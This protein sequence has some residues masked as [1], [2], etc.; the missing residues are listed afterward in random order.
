MQLKVRHRLVG[1]EAP[2]KR[3]PQ[4]GVKHP[5][6]RGVQFQ[7]QQFAVKVQP[8]HAA[9]VGGLLSLGRPSAIPRFVTLRI[10]DPLKGAASGA[11]A[12]IGQERFEVLPS[13]ADGDP[14]GAVPFIT[15]AR[16]VLAPRL[17]RGPRLVGRARAMSGR[18]MAVPVALVALKLQATAATG[19]AA[20]TLKLGGSFLN[21][22]A[23]ITSDQ[24]RLAA[25]IRAPALDNLKPPKSPPAQVVCNRHA[26]SLARVTMNANRIEK[27]A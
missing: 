16:R 27:A 12:H 25:P 1:R 4:A 9:A 18:R 8:C 10:V 23:A 21:R 17:C 3:R 19:G 24:P 20:A 2:L 22:D 14:L 13:I 26:Q 15:R 7:R 5:S 11:F 6:T